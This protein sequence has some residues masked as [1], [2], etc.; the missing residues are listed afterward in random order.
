M[1]YLETEFNI[2]LPT[3]PQKK[4]KD[5]IKEKIMND[6]SKSQLEFSYIEKVPKFSKKN[7]FYILTILENTSEISSK[8]SA[9]SE[10]T[11]P[12][13]DVSLN[14]EKQNLLQSN[15]TEI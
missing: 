6:F 9:D 5:E 3:S 14:D 7:Y 10:E 2:R 12:I 11:I 4:L 8:L 15:K 1:K 13:C